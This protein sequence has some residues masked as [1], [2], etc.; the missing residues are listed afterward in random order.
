MDDFITH[1]QVE[2]LYDEIQYQE[3]IE[4]YEWLNKQND[5]QESDQS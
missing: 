1:P 5:E 4:F 2:E 3:M